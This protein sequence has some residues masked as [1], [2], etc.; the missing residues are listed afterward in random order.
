MRGSGADL[1]VVASTSLSRAQV[2]AAEQGVRR[3][4]G[5]YE[6]VLT[7]ADVDAVLVAVAHADRERWVTAALQA[8]KHVLC[9]APMAS[10]AETAGRL[11]AAA[12]SAGRVLME[13]GSVRFHP[14][15]DALLDLVRG[16]DIGEPRLCGITVATHD[17]VED[18]VPLAQPAVSLVRWLVA[19]QPDRVAARCGR[20]GLVAALTFPSGAMATL[21]AISRAHTFEALEIIG[22]TGSVRVPRPLSATRAHDAVIEVDGEPVGSW[23]SDPALRMI[24]AF[25]DAVAGGFVILPADDAVSTAAVLDAIRL[26]S[27]LQGH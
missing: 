17:D 26:S 6:D 13:A 27:G 16:G 4:R 18:L 12:G 8:G 21:S 14:R 1:A 2:F 15:T 22:S 5:G 11:A 3:A 25:G 10:D 7:A 20:D 23:R 9:A 19:D 24:A